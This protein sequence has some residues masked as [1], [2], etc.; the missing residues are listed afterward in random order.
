[1]GPDNRIFQAYLDEM[2]VITIL[3]PKSYHNGISNR[4]YLIEDGAKQELTILETISLGANI[5]YI[6]RSKNEVQF[7]D[8]SWIVDEHDGM[9][10]LQIGSVIRTPEFDQR[11]YYDGNDLGV[12]Y[13]QNKV[14]LKLWAPTATAVMLKLV[15]P[16]HDSVEEYSMNRNKKG[17]WFI[18]R[19]GDYE[20]Y[21][22][23][24]LLRINQHWREVIDPYAVSATANGKKGVIVDLEKTR[25]NKP[26]L[27]R[28]ENPTDAI[29]YETHIRDFTIHTTSGVIHKGLYLGAQESNSLGKDGQPTCLSYVKDLGITHVE[30]LPFNDFEGVDELGDKQEYNWGYNPLHFNVPEG[31]YSSNP[32]D[33]YS[34]IIELKSMIHSIQTQGLRVI[35]DV[36]YNHVYI[37]E[38]SSFEKILPGYYFR[39][40]HHGMPSN[41]TGVGNDIA[42]ERLMVRKYI[43]DSIKFWMEEFHVDG[44][45]FDLMGIIDIETMNQVRKLVDEMDDTAI[46]LGEGWDLNTPISAEEKANIRNQKKLPRIAQFNDWFR[47]SI[48]GSTFNLYDRGY[49]FGNDHYHEAAMQVLTGSI[50]LEKPTQG[51][52]TEPNQTINYVESHD[53]H[54]LWDKLACCHQDTEFDLIQKRHR[55]ATAMVL[56]A[57]GI[58]FLHSGQE[59]FRTKNGVGNSYRSPDNVNWLDWDKK[60]QHQDNVDYLKGLIKIRKSHQAFRLPSA[61][62][63]RQHS[64]FLSF[65]KPLIGYF[66]KDVGQYGDWKNIVVLI[67]PTN[68]YIGIQLPII[69]VWHIL[70][71]GTASSLVPIGESSHIKYFMEP[72]SVSILVK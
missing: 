40:D 12:T 56:L 68:D 44:F 39:H 11:F 67:N 63:I 49:C 14:S 24:F 28:L 42:S 20:L 29:I 7:G 48:K 65:E 27:P 71:N 8:T 61:K 72:I 43:L 70:A 36:V 4:F 2:H 54:T 19:K 25:T 21:Q 37:R 9:T 41:G 45:R 10:D 64:S 62:E 33:P 69:G 35:M 30:F 47:D 18:E 57:Q 52:F 53:N 13:T 6:C 31:S 50:G 17:V 38:H 59:F 58:P 5:K 66:L 3:L 16:K 23:S 34:R 46:I 22:Y 1:M 26:E 55:L 32:A 51:I 60:I 15:S